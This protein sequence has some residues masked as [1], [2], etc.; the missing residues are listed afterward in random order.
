[1]AVRRGWLKREEYRAF[2]T[3]YP[4]RN[5][6]EFHFSDG[7][8]AGF[9]SRHSI[10]LRFCTN[11]SQWIPEDYLHLI[12][13]CLPFNWRNSQVGFGTSDEERVVGRY[14]L[15]SICNLDEAPLP[16]EYLDGQTYAD[17]GC[18]SVQ[19]KASHS[20][21]DKRQATVLLTVFGSGKPR[22]RHL[23]I[24]GGKEENSGRRAEY[25]QR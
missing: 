25:F 14:L 7:W 15:D 19:V 24:F 3:C 5:S 8:L 20:G 1:M 9:L 4:E 21:W 13:S 11:K 22:V 16:F 23:I 12:L 6:T 2:T 17:K 18:H 10:T